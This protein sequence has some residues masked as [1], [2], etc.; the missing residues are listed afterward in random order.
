MGPRNDD[1]MNPDKSWLRNRFTANFRTYNTL[2]VVQEEI[3]NQLD[4]L[5]ASS[6]PDIIQRGLEIG[7]G[8]GFFTRRLV[9]RYPST[10]WFINDLADG[11]EHYLTPLLQGVDTTY[12]WGDAETLTFPDHLD[13]VASASTIQWFDALPA[14]LRQIHQQ[15]NPNGALIIS[16]FGPENFREIKTTTGEGLSYY[17]ADAFQQ[18]VIEC[19]FEILEWEEYMRQLSFASPLDVLKHIRATG[20]N[21]IHPVHW[22]KGQLKHFETDYQNTYSTSDGDVTL[23]YHPMLMLARKI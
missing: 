16:T 2:A 13:L 11:A 5:L 23:T 20:V 18:L 6:G 14:F 9:R 1:T 4:Q 7:A 21:S 10:Q 17:E 8:T 12:L 19:G 22:T 3:C 15:L